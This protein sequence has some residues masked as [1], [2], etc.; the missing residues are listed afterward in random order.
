MLIFNFSYTKTNWKRF[1]SCDNPSKKWKNLP[2][3]EDLEN[4]WKYYAFSNENKRLKE[5]LFFDK[6]QKQTNFY[7]KKFNK[8]LYLECFE[9][10]N[11][12]YILYIIYNQ[13]LLNR[14]KFF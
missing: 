3:K 5:I 13:M 2:N 11:N 9:A 6:L 14:F 4:S 7:W 10:H 1:Y 12:K 8:V